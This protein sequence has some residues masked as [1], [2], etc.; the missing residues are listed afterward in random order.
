MEYLD[1]ELPIKELEEQLQKCQ[2]IG[3]ESEVDVT[4]TCK[5]IEKKLI[6]T[7]K[8]IYKNLT[9]WQR[10]QLSRHPNRPY[11]L[12]YIKALCGDSFLELH[13]DRNVKDDKAMIGGLGKIGDQ[14]FMFIGQQKGYNT[15]TRQYRNFGMAN[16]EGYRKAL[17]LMKSAEKF[18][19]PVVTF[20]DTPGAYPGLEAEERGQGEAIARNILEMSR[21]KVPVICIVI[22]EGASGG[23]LGIGVGDKFLML[24]NAWFSVI[25]PENCS[26]ILWRSWEYKEQAAEALKL[27]AKDSKS[28]KVID[29]IIKEPIG[30]AHSDREKTYL[31]VKSAILKSYDELKNLSPKDLVK[32]RM[33]KYMDMGVFKG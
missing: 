21:L 31:A 7:K 15:K 11:T 22:G 9:P 5:Q 6:A 26:S 32:K 30:G 13:G 27:T 19:I 33:E 23:A 14:S 2:V 28:I 20:I 8:D 12:D 17:R 16:P 1:F 10:V 18:G 4:E 3:Q 24:E 25:S 29:D